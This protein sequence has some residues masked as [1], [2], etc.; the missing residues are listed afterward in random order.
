M[1]D[2]KPKEPAAGPAKGKED[3]DGD[4]AAV[5]TD[6]LGRRVWDTEEYERRAK[7]RAA[8]EEAAGEGKRGTILAVKREN[9]REREKKVDLSSRIGKS[10]TID[11]AQAMGSGYYCK[12]CDCVLRDSINYLDHINGKKHQRNMG[13]SMRVERSSLDQVKAR[14]AARKRHI[15]ATK[16]GPAT[17]DLDARVA[18]LQE[19]EEERARQKKEAK[20]RKKMAAKEKEEKDAREKA[21]EIGFGDVDPEMAAMMGFGGFGSSKS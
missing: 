2:R 20:R 12:V 21:A 16:E 1:A 17:Y 8:E 6:A 14:L 3:G 5:K 4:G 11:S 10:R 19:E 18:A 9:L 7:A 15:E 13:M